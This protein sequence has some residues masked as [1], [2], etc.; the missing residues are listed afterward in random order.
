MNY[1][2]TFTE[3]GSD[4]VK[5]LE[6]HAQL[7]KCMEFNPNDPTLL[8]RSTDISKLYFTNLAK[9][10]D[11]L[12]EA[13]ESLPPSY[14]RINSYF[15]NIEPNNQVTHTIFIED[16]LSRQLADLGGEFTKLYN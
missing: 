7:L 16:K 15:D 10:S 12:H 5:L 8:D 9:I 13:T 14:T 2:S 1:K 4:I 6:L 11:E 3:V